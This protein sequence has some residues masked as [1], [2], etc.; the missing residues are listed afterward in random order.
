MKNLLLKLTKKLEDKGLTL[1]LTGEQ[2]MKELGISKENLNEVS[3]SYN[4]DIYDYYQIA[5]STKYLDE[6]K[7]H[8]TFN[9]GITLYNDNDEVGS[10]LEGNSQ[11]NANFFVGDLFRIKT[12]DY[13]S[14][15]LVNIVNILS[16]ISSDEPISLSLQFQGSY[17]VYFNIQNGNVKNVEYEEYE[18]EDELALFYQLLIISYNVAVNETLS[19]LQLL[20]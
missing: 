14:D 4:C 10:S 18:V 19:L 15:S 20:N 3:I 8:F 5:C 2:L 1:N 9:N 6:L 13:Y 7:K 16:T 11:P 12:L 17:Y